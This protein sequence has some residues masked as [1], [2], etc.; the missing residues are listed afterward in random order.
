MAGSRRAFTAAELVHGRRYQVIKSFQDYDGK[1]HPVGEVWR[2]V[3]KNFL[4]YEDGLS[5]MVEKEG[6]WASIRLQWRTETQGQIID[7]FSDY[8]KEL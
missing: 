4:P 7:S 2:F 1:L 3:E 6:K 5:L 8:V